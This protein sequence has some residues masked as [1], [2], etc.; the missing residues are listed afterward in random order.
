MFHGP[1]SD[2]RRSVPIGYVAGHQAMEGEEE[3]FI[4]SSDGAF[5]FFYTCRE[6][7]TGLAH[8]CIGGVRAWDVVHS[9]VLVLVEG[10]SHSLAFPEVTWWVYER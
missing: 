6:L 4:L 2:D 9:A 3:I 1:F 7:P 8:V 10:P 5:M